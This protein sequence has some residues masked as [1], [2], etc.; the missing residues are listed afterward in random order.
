MI[1]LYSSTFLSMLFSIGISVLNTHLLP[2]NEYGDVKYIVTIA[3]FVAS[4]LLLGYFVSGCRLLATKGKKER[5][6]IKGAMIII[7]MITSIVMTLVLLCFSLW[8]FLKGNNNLSILFLFG[9]IAGWALIIQNYINTSAQGDNSIH[10]IIIEKIAP[11]L[12][13]L[14]IGTLIFQLLKNNSIGVLVMQYGM[15]AIVGTTAIWLSSPSF[16]NLKNTIKELNLENRRYGRQ[17]YIGSLFGVSVGCL[18]PILLNILNS[19]NTFVGY[20]SLGIALA[21]PLSFLP[22]SIGT[23]YYKQFAHINRIDTKLLLF[24]LALCLLSYLAFIIL[25]YPVVSYVYPPEYSV[26][27]NYSIILAFGKLMHGCGDIF[28][29]FLGAHGRGKELRNGALTC[30]TILIVGNLIGVYFFGIYGAIATSVLSSMGY[31][32]S[33]YIYYFSYTKTGIKAA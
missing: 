19:D 20:F 4:V 11:G 32:V 3:S 22:S 27:A 33:M 16:T 2:P 28:N 25:I 24:A 10:L 15:I 21:A 14:L 29:R 18:A 8:H 9:S 7:L 5:R 31:F 26:V 1:A 12:L 6:E 13:Y 30:G 23:V 17:V